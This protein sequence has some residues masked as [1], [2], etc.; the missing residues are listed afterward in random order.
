MPK[1]Y[2]EKQDTLNDGREKINRS[3]D[4][5]YEAVDTS[6]GAVKTS[7]QA[8]T[9]S[10]EAK[11]ISN[12]A[13]DKS[14]YTQ[15]QLDTVTGS[16]TIDPAVEQLKVGSDGQTYPSPD[17]RIR[18]EH[19]KITT[20]LARNEKKIY[21]KSVNTLRPMVNFSLDDGYF[22]DISLALPETSQRG[23]PINVGY[24]N[25]SQLTGEQMLDLQN[26]HG[27]EFDAHTARH[28]DLRDLT[29]EE[30]EL[31]FTDNIAKME[32]M[33]IRPT[34]AMYPAG[35]S[36]KDTLDVVR[37]HFRAGLGSTAGT[38]Q[39][40]IDTYS[41]RRIY[42]DQYSM[43]Y[44]KARVD[45]IVDKGEGFLV[46]YSHTN[47]WNS[48]PET[49]DWFFEIMD[50]VLSKGVETATI[51]DILDVYENRL[52]IGSETHDN[53]YF[54]VGA[55]GRFVGTGL[56][57]IHNG[58]EPDVLERVPTYF[59]HGFNTINTFNTSN[60]SN[61]PIGNGIG[62][63]TTQ[64]ITTA[65]GGT[66]ASQTFE[67]R[68]GEKIT[69]SSMNRGDKWSEWSTLGPVNLLRSKPITADSSL[70]DFPEQKVT[71][72]TFLAGADTGFPGGDIGTL[73][74]SRIGANPVTHFQMFYPYNNNRVF[75]RTWSGS[76]WRSWNELGLVDKF[77][78]SHNFGE[79]PANGQMNY[80]FSASGLSGADVLSVS[81][82]SGIAGGI[83]YISYVQDANN[84]VLRLFNHTSSPVNVGTR[85]IRV[86]V[87]KF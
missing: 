4:R 27:W 80:T 43:E 23:V 58:Y 81:F 55:D 42:T 76:S 83:S 30:Q 26:N 60:A 65:M 63:L 36:N 66:D 38:N 61:L 72:L 52:D 3:I 86:I 84:Y 75:R 13:N 1:E 82:V 47:I 19:E 29:K 32:S 34:N 35:Y 51:S 21:S 71:V 50:Y 16:S 17:A 7:N 45:Y 14:D 78:E 18:S 40:P 56:P 70:A 62:I 48:R 54:R 6:N 79:I 24:I 8:V 25:S 73:M 10:N 12:E 37:K 87:N 77:S 64:K 67:A 22:N 49:K 5:A 39:V 53:K 33:G 41:L 85:S 44:M 69:R 9:T 59:K 2:I 31:E 28:P 57:Y 11:Q 20:Q 68:S 46:F 74:T 15:T